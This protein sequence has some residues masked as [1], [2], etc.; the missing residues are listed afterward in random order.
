MAIEFQCVCGK[1]LSVK[2]TAAGRKAKCPSCGVLMT[3]PGEAAP[4]PP[5]EPEGLMDQFSVDFAATKARAPQLITAAIALAVAAGVVFILSLAGAIGLGGWVLWPLVWVPQAGLSA[6]MAVLLTRAHPAAARWMSSA[7]SAAIAANY[8]L[9]WL[10]IQALSVTAW[11]LFWM[12]AAMVNLGVYG[13]LF[14]YFARPETLALFE[15]NDTDASAP[16]EGPD[17]T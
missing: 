14:W 2:D 15:K 4:E 17:T 9:F 16:T 7:A 10:A 11:G 8:V 3:V 5:P 1:T 13:V 6:L 12:F